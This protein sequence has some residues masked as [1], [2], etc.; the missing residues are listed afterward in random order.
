MTKHN[1]RKKKGALHAAPRVLALG[2]TALLGALCSAAAPKA[3]AQTTLFAD[4]FNAGTLD[5]TKWSVADAGWVLQRA[6]FGQQPLMTQSGSDRFARLRLDTYCPVAWDPSPSDG[7]SQYF[8]GTEMYTKQL[9][10][11]GSGVEFETRMRGNS[12]PP[13]AIMAFFTYGDAGNFPTTARRDEIDNEILGNLSASKVWS[14]VWSGWNPNYGYDD[15]IHDLTTIPDVPGYNRNNW[16]I[17]KIRWLNNRVEIYINN[18]LVRTEVNIL[19]QMP[20]SI[21]FNIWAADT[22]WQTAYNASL[23]TTTS[24]RNNRSYSVDVDYLRVRSIA[25]SAGASLG[26][27]TGLTASYFD[28]TDFTGAQVSR[29]DERVNNDWNTYFTE[30]SLGPTY[31]ARYTGQVQAQYSQPYTFTVKADDMVRLWINNQLLISNDGVTPAREYS[32]TVNLTSGVKTNIRLEYAN[33]SAG[34]GVK[35]YWSSPSTPK[36]LVPQSQLYYQSVT[37]TT[38]PTVNVAAPS[39]QYS[40]RSALTA[41]GSALDSGTGVTRVTALVYRAA[42]NTYWNG[43][44][45]TSAVLENNAAFSVSGDTANW[46]YNLPALTQGLYAF[47]AAAQDGANNK[48]YSPWIYFYY[49]VTPPN[50]VISTPVFGGTYASG[51]A[52]SGTAQDVGPGVAWVRGRLQRYSDGFYWNGGQWTPTFS[53]LAANGTANWNVPFPALAPGNYLFQALASDYVGNITYTAPNNFTVR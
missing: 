13:G 21:H 19:P 40:Y 17:Y 45:W 8:Y 37:D 53:E 49:D 9:F 26:T 11:L 12:L 31:S 47:Q 44:Q 30:P 16:N 34:G 23:Q 35:L 22:Y 7:L 36:Q 42:D 6:R 5:S 29:I 46:N 52:G 18:V 51:V 50:V 32:A 10:A 43:S 38:P 3:A 25:P 2:L 15:G 14:H 1:Q 39:A 33:L 20:Q 41:S 27:G 24:A 4:E 28:N 48:T